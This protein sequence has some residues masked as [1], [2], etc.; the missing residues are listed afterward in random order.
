[1]PHFSAMASK[2]GILLVALPLASAA[3]KGMLVGP[4]EADGLKSV[5]RTAR[6][7]TFSAIAFKSGIL[8]VG[9]PLASAATMG[10]L[11]RLAGADG[12]KLGLKTARGTTDCPLAVWALA[13]S[14]A[15]WALAAS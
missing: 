7:L 10:M 12:L 13:A 6:P 3:T 9:W 8:L 15:P 4:K 5:L 14:W 11:L 2:S 1:M